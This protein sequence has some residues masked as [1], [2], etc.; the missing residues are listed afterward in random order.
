MAITLAV[1][2]FFLVLTLNWL[3]IGLSFIG[4]FLAATYP[5]TKRYTYLPQ[6]YLGATFG[7]AVPM[8]FAAQTGELPNVAWLMYIAAILWATVYD[9]M[10][11]MVDREED[12][13]LG[14]K[15]TA[16]L[17]GDAD[18]VILGVLQIIMLLTWLMI[19]VE[20]ELGIF[21]YLGVLFAAGLAAYHQYLIRQRN[22]DGCFKAFLHNNWLGFA[23]FIGIFLDYLIS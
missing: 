6:M 16:I 20:A 21:F 10:Y 19:G 5:F 12:I 3:T 23:L 18:R 14:V 2:S 1:W 9:T 11:G 22:R 4:V 15:S 13:K 17:F 7:W 8:A